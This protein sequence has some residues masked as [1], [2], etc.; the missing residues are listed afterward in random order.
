MTAEEARNKTKML[1][2]IRNLEEEK[3]K[4]QEIQKLKS[5]A[6]KNRKSTLEYALDHIKI[7]VEEGRDNTSVFRSDNEYTVSLL[8]ED[9]HKLGYNTGSDNVKY[10]DDDP[11][12]DIIIIKW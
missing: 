3:K 7:A 5:E 6:K 4:K 2:E 9:L 8:M 1:L 11:G 10:S 12:T